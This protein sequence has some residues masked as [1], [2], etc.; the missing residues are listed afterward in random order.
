MPLSLSE[1]DQYEK[2]LLLK[3]THNPK[4]FLIYNMD[5][6][7]ISGTEPSS[8]ILSQTKLFTKVKSDAPKVSNHTESKW[9]GVINPKITISVNFDTENFDLSNATNQP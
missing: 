1:L 5:H 9:D 3:C 7:R 6:M 8:V 4:T 2:R